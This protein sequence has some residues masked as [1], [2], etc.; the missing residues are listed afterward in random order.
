MRLENIPSIHRH[1][2][3]VYVSPHFDDVAASCGGKILEQ[4]DRGE[5]VLV[6]TVF[7]GTAPRDPASVSNPLKPALDYPRRRREDDTA[8]QRMGV[9]TRKRPARVLPVK[10]I[11]SGARSTS[12]APTSLPP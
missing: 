3:H 2:D 8:M 5:S 1:Y 7:T 11:L 9:Q 4:K 10:W 12:A 6:V